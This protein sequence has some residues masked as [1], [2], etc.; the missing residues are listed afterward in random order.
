MPFEFDGRVLEYVA[1]PTK[2]NTRPLGWPAH[3][4]SPGPWVAAI[5]VVVR[6]PGNDTGPMMLFPAGTVITK[7]HVLETARAFRETLTK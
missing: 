5:A 4:A 1:V 7:E 2:H 6:K 3:K